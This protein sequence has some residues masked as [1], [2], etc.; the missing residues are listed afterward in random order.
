M[1]SLKRQLVFIQGEDTNQILTTQIQ[2]KELED[3]VILVNGVLEK[4]RKLEIALVKVNRNFKETITSISHDIR[5]PLTSAVG[6]IQMLESE[7]IS[8]EKKKEYIKVVH[9]RIEEVKDLLD[10]L[11]EYARIESGELVLEQ[12]PVNVNN[13]LRDTISIFYDDYVQKGQTP[14]IDIC[15]EVCTIL[16]DHRAMKRTFENIILNSLV[17]GIG[18]YKII[19]EKKAD[20]IKICFSNCTN[21]I[22]I[23]DLEHIFERF[24]TSDRSRS[25]KTTGLGL[26]IAK[27]FILYMRGNIEAQMAGDI[28]MIIIELPEYV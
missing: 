24:Y 20:N 13:I 17:H 22:E 2:L 5:T 25:K 18:D 14:Q 27:S 4:H 11:F 7:K 16:G 10:Q 21:S 19:L 8:T 1:R 26:S 28:F 23:Q 12:S 3:L 6:Y 9:K 15:E